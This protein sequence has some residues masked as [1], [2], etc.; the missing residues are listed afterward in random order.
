MIFNPQI[1]QKDE[2]STAINQQP[3]KGTKVTKWNQVQQRNL[4]NSQIC[5]ESFVPFRG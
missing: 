2:V 1:T 4:A 5:F 3:Q